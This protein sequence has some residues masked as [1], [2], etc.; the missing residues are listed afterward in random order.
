MDQEMGNLMKYQS[1][2]QASARVFSTIDVL[3]NTLINNTG[4]P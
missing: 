4:T 1:A 3:L 2:Y